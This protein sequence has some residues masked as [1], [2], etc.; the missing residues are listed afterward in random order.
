MVVRRLDELSALFFRFVELGKIL[1]V[2]RIISFQ[3][4]TLIKQVK[5]GVLLFDVSL[6]EF[7]GYHTKS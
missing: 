5:S 3:I 7:R 6:M 4:Y 1:E 2:S